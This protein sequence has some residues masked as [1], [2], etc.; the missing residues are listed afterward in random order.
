LPAGTGIAPFRSF[1]RRIFYDGIA[2]QPPQPF[3]D[4]AMFWLL[5]GFANT[6]RCGDDGDGDRDSCATACWFAIRVIPNLCW[7]PSYVV[8]NGLKSTALSCV[9][10]HKL[11][12]YCLFC[13]V[14]YGK[15][16]KAALKA[17]SKHVQ[18]LGLLLSNCSW[19]FAVNKW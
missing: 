4:N 16:Q 12:L 6:D 11:L 18:H 7:H 15:K 19:Y 8:C 2:G 13:S 17:N 9:F 1:W 14:H 3:S 5:S 10:V